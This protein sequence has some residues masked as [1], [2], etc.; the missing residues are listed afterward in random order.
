M[1]SVIM[2]VDESTKGLMDEIQSGI[3][4]SI[5]DGIRGVKNSVKSVNDN[6]DAILRKFKNFD[7]LNSSVEQLRT[8][9]AESKKISESVS[10]LQGSIGELKHGSEK[11]EKALSEQAENLELLIQSV[12]ETQKAISSVSR[13]VDTVQSD[14]SENTEKLNGEVTRLAT[15]QENFD[16]VYSAN[17]AKHAEFESNVAEQI[18]QLNESV[19]KLQ[20]T[21]D[22]VVNYVTPFWKKLFN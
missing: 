9:A 4:S 8:L 11:N 12:S 10:P 20:L 2:Q 16:K 19:E 18:K 7:G 13:V 3:T 14:F 17:E 6:T 1:N 21:L 15:V 22:I 5:E